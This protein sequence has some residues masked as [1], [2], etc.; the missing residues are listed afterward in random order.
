MI[1]LVQF[2][3]GDVITAE[4][5][6]P[7]LNSV[8]NSPN[9]VA[10]LL[11][12]IL[13]L[14]AAVSLLGTGKR[15]WLYAM[16]GCVMLAAMALT[17]SKGG[18]LLGLPAALGLVVIAWLGRKGGYL[19]L[20]GVLFEVLAMIPLS[21]LPR[22]QGLFDFSSRT[23]TSF[24]RLQLWK[25]AVRMVRDHPIFGVGLDQFLYQYRGHY[26]L[27]AA[28]Q[29]PDLSTPH[30][31]ILNYWTRLGILG[32]AAGVWMQIAFWRMAW[33]A[34]RRLKKVSR[35]SYALI[36]GLMAGMAA[37]LAHGLVDEPFF[38]IDMA[39]LF[40]FALGLVHQ[41][42]EQANIHR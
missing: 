11:G 20:V 24:F 2:A 17:L 9:S 39:F 27:P 7:R 21:R 4:G 28:W 23:S 18:I 12:R 25:S 34:Q 38:Q 8:Y 36:V 30:T 40:F 14:V 22:F 3:S 10:L 29:E 41:L 42:A 5:G 19:V 35:S 15:R 33:Q 13:P 32:V 26:I 1:G 37:F 6:I 31:L 16:G